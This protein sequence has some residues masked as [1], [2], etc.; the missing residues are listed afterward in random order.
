MPETTDILYRI[1]HL[2]RVLQ[3]DEATK[4]KYFG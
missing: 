2:C 3:V 4:A 1:E